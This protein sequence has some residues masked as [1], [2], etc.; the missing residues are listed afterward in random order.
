MMITMMMMIAIMVLQVLWLILGK[1]HSCSGCSS[2]DYN[3]PREKKAV[4]SAAAGGGEVLALLVGKFFKNGA[5]PSFFF[6]M[7]R[8]KSGSC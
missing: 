3:D 2:R 4:G 6:A 7:V 5:A 1:E 8:C